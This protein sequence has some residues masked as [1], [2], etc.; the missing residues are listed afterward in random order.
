MGKHLPDYTKA[1]VQPTCIEK[2]P[3]EVHLGYRDDP[4]QPPGE[5]SPASIPQIFHD[6]EKSM[7]KTPEEEVQRISMP[8][9]RH[10]E[11]DHDVQIFPQRSLP[12]SPQ[13][14]INMV[15]QPGSQ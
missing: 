13:R 6:L 5:L 14:D 10:R 3:G 11:Y 7:Q 4:Q 12:A 15:R 8:K 2:D 9:S 1:P